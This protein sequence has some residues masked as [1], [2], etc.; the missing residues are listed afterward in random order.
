MI[1]Q[2]D[3]DLKPESCDHTHDA[4]YCIKSTSLDGYNSFNLYIEMEYGFTN[5]TQIIVNVFKY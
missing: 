4:Q 5:T 3:S 1:N 2:P